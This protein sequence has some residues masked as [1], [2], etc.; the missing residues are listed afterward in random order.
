MKSVKFE[1]SDKSPQNIEDLLA[2][3]FW[4]NPELSKEAKDFID[5]ITAWS[6]T[7]TPYKVAEWESYC[8]R[9]NITQSTYHNMLKR[10]KGAGLIDK[11]YNN[12]RQ[13]HELHPSTRFT[14]QL[15]DLAKIWGEYLNK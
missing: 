12:T 15:V 3:I 11:T 1:I 4:K 2:R 14:K 6:K 13:T 5:H 8:T 10:L 7:E 9:K